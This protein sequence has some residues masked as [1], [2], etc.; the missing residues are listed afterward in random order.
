METIY[1]TFP[2]KWTTIGSTSKSFECEYDRDENKRVNFMC[3]K[4]DGKPKF[5]ATYTC[6]KTKNTKNLDNLAKMVICNE[7]SIYLHKSN[8]QT[9]TYI[10][11]K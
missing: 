3:S 2:L 11:A 4:V 7:I 6:I 8:Y 9:E 1:G 5:V 10:Y